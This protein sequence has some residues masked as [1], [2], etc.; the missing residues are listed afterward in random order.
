MKK[1]GHHHIFD[2][3]LSP[4]FQLLLIVPPEK[5]DLK[6]EKKGEKQGERRGGKDRD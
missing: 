6:K 3:I 4:S 5:R 1:K 2:A